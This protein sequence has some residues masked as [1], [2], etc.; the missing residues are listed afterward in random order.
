MAA[1]ATT[2]TRATAFRCTEGAAAIAAAGAEIFKAD[3]RKAATIA[4]SQHRAASN[5]VSS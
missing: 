5:P 1:T 2:T 4:T 3:R